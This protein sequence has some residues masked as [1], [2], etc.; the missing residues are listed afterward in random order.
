MDRQGR[1]GGYKIGEERYDVYRG[2]GRKRK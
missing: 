2:I 1:E